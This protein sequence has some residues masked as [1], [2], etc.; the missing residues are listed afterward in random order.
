MTS[1]AITIDH[2]GL[3]INMRIF[4]V[5]EKGKCLR[6]PAFW[7]KAQSLG[8]L[9][10]GCAAILVIIFPGLADILTVKNIAAVTAALGAFNLYFTNA[11][12]EKV[13][14]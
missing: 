14:V 3:D 4:E 8:S 11:T 2:G 12:S 9:V 5:L 7:K 6:D 13:G 1:L 10:G